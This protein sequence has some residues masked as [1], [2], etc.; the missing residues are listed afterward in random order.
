MACTL[1]Y[2]FKSKCGITAE[3]KDKLAVKHVYRK[4]SP[5]LETQ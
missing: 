4:A 3:S 1:G 2:N 5:S